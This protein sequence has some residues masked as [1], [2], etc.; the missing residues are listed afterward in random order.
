[1]KVIATLLVLLIAASTVPAMADP[2][3]LPDLIALKFHG[4][5]C[6]KCKKMGSGFED[7]QTKFAGQS[8]LFV[9]IDRTNQTTRKTTQRPTADQALAT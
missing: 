8:A 2:P 9:F 3:P 4:D 5:W 1:M 7:L 6:G